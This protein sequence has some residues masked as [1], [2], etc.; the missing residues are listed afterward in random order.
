MTAKP[1]HTRAGTP[2]A[3]TDSG[4]GTAQR[5]LHSRAKN[6]RPLCAA[7]MQNHPRN[8]SQPLLPTKAFHQSNGSP[9]GKRSTKADAQET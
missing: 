4:V 1:M 6:R 7:N 8:Q 5:M 9:N 3:G 2:V